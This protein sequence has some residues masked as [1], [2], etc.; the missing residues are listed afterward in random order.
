MI[1]KRVFKSILSLIRL[2][3]F[4]PRD[5]VHAQWAD[6]IRQDFAETSPLA[7]RLTEDELRSAREIT[8]HVKT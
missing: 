5:A 4:A 1:S 3:P 2:P 8:P 7:I 6:T